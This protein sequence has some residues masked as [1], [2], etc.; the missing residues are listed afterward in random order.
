MFQWKYTLRANIYLSI[1]TGVN[2]NQTILVKKT[3]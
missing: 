3:L 1:S 2:V